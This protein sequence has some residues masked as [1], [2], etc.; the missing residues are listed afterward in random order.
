[1]FISYQVANFKRQTSSLR[2]SSELIAAAGWAFDAESVVMARH[3]SVIP[4]VV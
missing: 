3:V 2:K 1:M 4:P